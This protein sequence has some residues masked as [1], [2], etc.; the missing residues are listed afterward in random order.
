MIIT[1]L[2]DLIFGLLDILLFFEI[3][4]LDED[5][6][7]S[8]LG[9]IDQLFDIAGDYI[10]FFIPWGVVSALTLP[11]IIILNA[12]HIYHFV[13]WVLKKIPMLGIE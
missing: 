8:V 13:M 5:S 11:L 6:V 7:N 2:V 10:G 4:G 3:P 12:E 9:F 1:A